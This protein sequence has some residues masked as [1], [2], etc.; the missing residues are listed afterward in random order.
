MNGLSVAY[1]YRGK[2]DQ[3]LQLAEEILE[4]RQRRFGSAHGDTLVAMN[5]VA[6]LYQ[7]QTQVDKA[8]SLYEETLA[9]MR[10]K[11]A[12]LHPERLNTTRNLAH[13]YHV[14]EQIDKAA[15]L[16]EGLV[17]DF[18]KAYGLDDRATQN[19]IDD[20]IA[21]DADMGW[22]DKATALLPSVRG[23]DESPTPKAKQ[24]QDVR[25]KRLRALIERARPA[26]E[27][28][29]GELKAKSAD[30]P[31]TLAARQAFA[32]V[33]RTQNRTSA[34]AYHLSAVL[35]A[36]QRLMGDEHV[37]VQVCRLELGTLRL[38]QKKYADAEKLLVEAFQGLGQHES[39]DPAQV[40]SQRIVA[41][42]G[43]V[44]LYL[45]RLYDGWN[46]KDKAKEG[47]TNLMDE[48]KK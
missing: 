25:E 43:L 41:L 5:N 35:D 29:H 28:Y 10:S 39:K 45:G 7:Q 11:F 44:R 2:L 42:E 38:Q 1:R 6:S 12:P 15:E 17:R 36:R 21:Y 18:K 13:A 14:A 20:L 31:D 23:G 48:K 46:K 26:A 32:V 9:G 22:C 3:A 24:K 37:D 4:V 34:A 16:Q 40:K 33:L 47:R 19:C 8:L 30:H 27:K